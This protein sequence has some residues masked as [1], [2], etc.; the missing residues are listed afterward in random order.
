MTG[1]IAH[2]G[3]SK[4]FPENTMLAFKEAAK[5]DITGIE[6]DVQLTS[7]GHVVICHDEMIDRTSNG[8]GFIKD[9][10]LAELKTFYFYG[11]FQGQVEE[12]EDIQLPTLGEFFEWFKPLD[13][14]VNIELKTNIFRYDGLV[15]KVND[16]IQSFDLND[17]VVLS[18]FQHHTMNNA[19]K[20]NPD[21]KTGLLTISGILNPGDYMASHGHEFY[22]PFFM[23][24][25]SEDFDNLAANKIGINTYTVNRAEDMEKLINAK[26]TNIITDD[27]ALGL[28]TLN[29]SK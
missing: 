15:E 27:V 21:L 14:M 25:E 5:F 4:L 12:N 7:D 28:E 20:V 24:L 29:A 11:K 16:L 13:I 26:V 9:M 19:K 23:T 8:T 10:T 22:H 18:S 2:R 17:R 6:L 1:I 3:Y